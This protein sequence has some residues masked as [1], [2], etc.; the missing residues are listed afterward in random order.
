[1][2]GRSLAFGVGAALA[3]F[4]A[5]NFITITLGLVNALTRQH[6][7]LEASAYLLGP[8][9]NVLPVCCRRTT[10]PGRPSRPRW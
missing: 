2:L 7:W 3:F 4:P 6:V 9:L 10:T 8:N 1:M 5:D